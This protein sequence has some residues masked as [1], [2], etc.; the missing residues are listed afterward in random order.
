MGCLTH[1][2]QKPRRGLHRSALLRLLRLKPDVRTCDIG[3]FFV[4]LTVHIGQQKR[5]PAFPQEPFNFYPTSLQASGDVDGV[6]FFKRNIR[7]F[8]VFTGTK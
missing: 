1:K 3:H 5:A 6:T 8:N 4:S 7:L 2:A